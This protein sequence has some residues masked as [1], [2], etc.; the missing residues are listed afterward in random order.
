A[1][2]GIWATSLHGIFECDA[3]R[4]SFLTEVAERRAKR[5]EPAATTFAAHR[6]AEIDRVADAIEEHLD[7]D[8]ILAIIAQGA[9]G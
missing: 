1:N 3:F 4:H 9:P 8:A 2:A 6:Q 5:F 7:L